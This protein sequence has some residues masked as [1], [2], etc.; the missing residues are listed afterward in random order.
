MALYKVTATYTEMST[1]EFIVDAATPEDA[2]AIVAGDVDADAS[3][4][5]VK[6]VW[7]GDR[8]YIDD[9]EVEPIT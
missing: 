1:D 2:K 4:E 8:F 6:N 3:I 5:S 9:S 7:V